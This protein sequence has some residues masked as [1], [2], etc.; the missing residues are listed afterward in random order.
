MK[1]LKASAGSGKT[2]RLS[3][4]YLELLEESKVS[5]PYRH[6]LAVTFTNKATAEMKN[7]ILSDLFKQSANSPKSKKILIQLLHDYG[8][9][10][11]STIDKFF[12]HTLKAFSRE[13]GQFA[14]YQIEL[15]RKSLVIEAMDRLLDSLTKDQIG[16]ISWIQESLI[17]NLEQGDSPKLEDGLYDM[18]YLLKNEEHRVLVE[19]LGISEVDLYSAEKLK[20][21]KKECNRIIKHFEDGMKALGYPFKPKT[22]ITYIKKYPGLQ[23]FLDEHYKLYNTAYIINKMIFSLGLAGEFYKAF[24]TL[25]KEKNV[26][27]I[28][29]TNT[30]LK[31]LI[32]GSDAPFIYEKL[33]VRYDS[34]L[35][36]EFQ[37]TSNVQWDNFL[38]LL[39]ES[40]ARAEF[41][42]IVGD[43]KQSIY[44]FRGSEWKLLGSE[45]RRSFTDA[46]EEAM[47]DNWRSTT[48]IVNFNNGLFTFLAKQLGLE[49]IYSDVCQNPKTLD[50]GYLK[51]DFVEDQEA[52]VI[53]SIQTA[54][55]NGAAWSDIAI[56]VRNNNEGSALAQKLISLSIPVI[57]DESLSVKASWI[58]SR[59]T[60]L[61]SAFENPED[62]INAY[63]IQSLNI[64]VPK[65]YHSLVD[66]CEL[67]LCS[68]KNNYPEVFEGETLF[69]QAFMD[70]LQNWTNNNGHNLKDFLNFWTDEKK[71]PSIVS[72]DDSDAIRILTIHKSKGLQF[73]Y[74]I[75]PYAEKV[76]FFND[77]TVKWCSLKTNSVLDG[78]YPISMSSSIADT[79]FV[80]DYEEEKRAQI[81]DGINVFY[82]ALTRPSRCLHIISKTPTKTFINS[83]NK[84]PDYK[85]FSQCLYHYLN[86]S[87]SYSIGTI[88]FKTD[89]ETN[90]VLNFSSSY[91]SIPIGD[92]VLSSS[93]A[94]DFFID[95]TNVQTLNSSA[96]LRGIA[97][98]DIL[99]HIDCLS[100]VENAIQAALIEG[101]IEK[102]DVESIRSLFIERIAAHPQWFNNASIV[103][104]ERSIF[105][106]NGNEHRPDRV[107][108]NGNRVT[109]I[110]FKFG[111]EKSSYKYQVRRYSYLYRQMGYIVDSAL[112]WYVVEDKI[113]NEN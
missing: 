40:H 101:S 65:T 106:S 39:K 23:E 13:I 1:I 91:P 20:S 17:S 112:I 99:S 63:I 54:R 3:K 49:D 98:H 95:E 5:N 89:K 37:D 35:L 93:D 55:E 61:L 46:S 92:R 105:D 26:L 100:D 74:V 25:L 38:P 108:V 88:S 19:K 34:F 15:D 56:L 42:L 90:T 67:L 97:L 28:D 22:K 10:S 82:V 87:D 47:Q 21:L 29:E 33:G 31:K 59:L 62:T 76:K 52:T 43:V 30:I 32:N 79:L 60:A 57:S 111:E 75:F 18:A 64:E 2:Y 27:C 84:K 14:D 109:I 71:Q 16:L 44:R 94:S 86:G 58:V 85:N 48:N 66:F 41:N 9:F 96:R 102:D 12:Q 72:P 107:I 11:V 4:T 50:E 24:D 7:R 8:S 77:K 51:V 103:Y 36:D 45:V 110:D 69:I 78:I 53:Q 73:P 104:K 6:I 81:I 68:L 83:M 80:S 113:V 70:E